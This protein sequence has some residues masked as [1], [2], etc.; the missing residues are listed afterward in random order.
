MPTLGACILCGTP[1]Y[2][3]REDLDGRI[4][5]ICSVRA[6]TGVGLSGKM[7]QRIKELSE[8]GEWPLR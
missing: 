2:G 8:R 3:D 6:E 1:T 5:H 7:R 4:H